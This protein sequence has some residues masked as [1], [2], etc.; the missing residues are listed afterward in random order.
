MT[1]KAQLDELT[2]KGCAVSECTDT[3]PLWIH[4]VC[5]PHAGLYAEYENGTI[6]IVC[7][8]CEKPVVEVEIK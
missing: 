3:H 8:E 2:K 6:R 1:T 7:K 4:S 5:H